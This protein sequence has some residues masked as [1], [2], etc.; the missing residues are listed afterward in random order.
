MSKKN[1]FAKHLKNISN[2]INNLLEKNLNKLNSKNLSYLFKN[3][4]I[5]LTFVA[6]F[7]IFVSYL[8]LP[9]FYNKTDIS[10]ELKKELQD[11][12]DLNFR[13]SENIKYNFFPKPHFIITDSKIYYKQE[14][15]SKISK[16]KIFISFDN[17]FSISDIEIRDVILENSNFNL[18]AKNYNF[19]LELLNRSFK[20]GDLIIEDSNVIFRHSDSEVLLISKIFKMKYYYESNEEKNIFFS[21]NEIFNIPF[22]IESFFSEGKNEFFSSINLNLMK[23]KIQNQLT[24]KNEKKIGKSEFVSN[25]LRRIAEYQI[26][27]NSF[28]FYIF[29]KIDQPDVI[30]KGKFN[31]KPFYANLEGNQNEINFNYLFGTNAIIAQLLKTEIFNN[32]NI[33]FKLNINADS[34]YKN[35]N[36]KNIKLNSKIQDGLIDTDNTKFEWRD[37][38]D[39]ELL[40]SLIFVKNGELVLDGK[41]KLN[42]KDHNKLYKFLLTPKNY[43]NQIKQIDLNFTYNFDQKIAEF[44]DIKI[45]NKINQE[46]NK[47]LNNVFF[48]KDDLQNK[49]YFKKLLNEA[50]KTYAG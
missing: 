17:L 3:N 12:L 16:S 6:L 26:E 23:L 5:I 35:S 19:F 7:V 14:E 1:F 45:D 2:F 50:I 24:F 4:K 9:T 31:F 11:K 21:E 33:D 10:E 48:K 18:N 29:D 8:L 15:I 41:L 40:D 42:V 43:R 25:K 22:T 46:V 38:A 47:I 28:N 37:I 34:I 13:F 44:K 30:Y 32:T 20:N 39:F 27:K 36:F 49:I